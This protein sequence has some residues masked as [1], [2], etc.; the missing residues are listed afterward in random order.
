MR[1]RR[2]GSV[3][4]LSFELAK[5]PEFRQ[6]PVAFDGVGRHLE[7]FR[8]LLHAQATEEPQFDG[9]A[10]PSVDLRQCLQCAVERHDV[11]CRVRRHDELFVQ[12]H[13]LCAAAAFVVSAIA[14]VI[15]EDP[16]HQARRDAEKVR[17][18]L[19]ADA[20]GIRQ[21]QECLVHQ[22]RGL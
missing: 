16:P 20:P 11:Q 10:L 19:P 18:V 1:C 12:R 2:S 5:Q 6:S 17:A 9:S 14:G 3:T 13:P 7:H 21:S 4:P 8:R 15:D 22:R